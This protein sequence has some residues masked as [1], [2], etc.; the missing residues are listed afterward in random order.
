[1][2]LL[3]LLLLLFIYLFIYLNNFYYDICSKSKR[4]SSRELMLFTM[5]I[6]QDNG[7]KHTQ[8]NNNKLTETVGQGNKWKKKNITVSKSSRNSSLLNGQVQ[9]FLV[10]YVIWHTCP[11]DDFGKKPMWINNNNNKVYLNCKSPYY[12]LTENKLKIH[13]VAGHSK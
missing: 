6:T 3:L 11:A 1:M 13:T 9:F 2:Q 8:R 4:S 7:T 12:K 10:K 5:H